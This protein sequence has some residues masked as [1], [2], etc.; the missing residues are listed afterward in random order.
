MT[1]LVVEEALKRIKTLIPEIDEISVEQVVLGLGYTGVKLSDGHS[2]LCYT[3][4]TE[5]AQT[6]RHCQVS[7]L[8]GTLVG[9]PRPQI[10]RPIY[11]HKAKNNPQSVKE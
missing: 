7:D 6:T 10:N 3:S 4:Q 5:I 8:A 9:T 1:G 11:K 2:G